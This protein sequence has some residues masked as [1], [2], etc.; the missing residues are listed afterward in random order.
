MLPLIELFDDGSFRSEIVASTDKRTRE[1]VTSVRV[2][3]YAVEDPGRPGGRGTR[4]RLL[5][6]ILDPDAAPAAE[7]AALYPKRWDFET[8]LDEIKTHE[9][10][11]NVV[12]RSKTPEGVRQE[13]YGYLCTHYAI[14]A[15]MAEVA[16]KGGVGPDR[17]SFTRSGVSQ[18][19][20]AV[21][22]GR[23]RRAARGSD[24]FASPCV[25][26]RGFR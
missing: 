17:V 1:Q 12:L 22:S 3:E 21:M 13:A 5:T 18:R 25:L 9:R 16:G 14:R 4:Y 10:G 6:T 11:P 20:G 2:V 8:M 24:R 19:G 23:A 7:L 26:R 15:L